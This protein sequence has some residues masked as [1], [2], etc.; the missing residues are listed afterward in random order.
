MRILE[1]AIP[2]RGPEQE[3]GIW[4]SYTS[5]CIRS[6]LLGLSSG[7]CKSWVVLALLAHV[8]YWNLKMAKGSGSIQAKRWH[9]LIPPPA[10]K[11]IHHCLLLV[12][13]P[14]YFLNFLISLDPWLPPPSVTPRACHPWSSAVRQSVYWPAV[15]TSLIYSSDYSQIV[16]SDSCGLSLVTSQTGHACCLI[17]I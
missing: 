1:T 14:K 17:K 3:R 7:S 11:P 9:P 10:T 8:G 13:S 6:H 16:L 12:L 15:W 4:S 5:F 2:H